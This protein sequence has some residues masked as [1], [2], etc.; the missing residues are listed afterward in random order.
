MVV[1]YHMGYGM[2]EEFHQVRY[3]GS[4]FWLNCSKEDSG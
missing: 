2:H 1:R 4:G 3:Q